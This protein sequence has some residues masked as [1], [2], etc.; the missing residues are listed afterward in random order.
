VWHTEDSLLHVFNHQKI[1]NY[2]YER[3]IEDS[4]EEYCVVVDEETDTNTILRSS[5]MSKQ[6]QN[7]GIY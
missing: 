6:H 5:V 2:F 1:Y 3:V 4:L 7:H